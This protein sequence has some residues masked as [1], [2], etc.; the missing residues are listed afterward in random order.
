MII[1]IVIIIVLLLKSSY[2]PVGYKKEVGLELHPRLTI[3]AS[4]NKASNCAK[5]NSAQ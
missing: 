4:S 1:I 2:I 3:P 5:G